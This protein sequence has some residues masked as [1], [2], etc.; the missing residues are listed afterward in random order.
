MAEIEALVEQIMGDGS[1]PGAA[2]GIVKDG[3]LAYTEWFGVTELDSD[4]PVTP[5]SDFFMASVSK[6]VLAMAIMQLV[7]EGRIDL[8]AP[9]VDYLPYF[10]LGGTRAEDITIRQL[11]SHTSGMPDMED[12]ERR[13]AYMDKEMRTDEGALEDYVRSLGDERLLF[14]P[15]ED[16]SYSSI[17]FNIL[18]DVIAKVSG[19]SFEDYMQEQILTPL[20]MEDSSFLL[21]EVDPER[22]VSPHGY[23]SSGKVVVNNFIPYTRSGAPASTLFS[24]LDD[25]TR[26]A[27]ANL[28]H[29]ELDS[30]QVLRDT[31]Y[32]DMWAPHAASPFR[33]NPGSAGVSLWTRL[34]GGEMEGHPLVGGYGASFGYQTHLVIFPEAG[35]AVV[36]MVNAYDPAN[37]ALH[38]W[39]IGNGIAELLLQK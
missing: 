35:I 31:G 17:G 23:T 28:N 32:A 10:T 37:G 13:Y 3:E 16:W 6:C 39:D 14:S 9:V 38:A 1:V 18:G 27:L 29:G 33:G 7:E 25:M 30:V 8:D 15:G 22:L 5:D 2:I 26:F 21:S 36:T 34:V 19:Q 20:G 4:D 24:T 11:L 12:W